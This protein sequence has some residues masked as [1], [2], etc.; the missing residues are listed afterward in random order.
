MRLV[1]AAGWTTG[2]AEADLPLR[3]HRDRVTTESPVVALGV[4]E[5]VAAYSARGILRPLRLDGCDEPREG[6]RG[7]RRLLVGSDVRRRRSAPRARSPGASSPRSSSLS[8]IGQDDAARQSRTLRRASTA[9][10]PSTTSA[11]SR[12]ATVRSPSLARE[13]LM[14]AARTQDCGLGH[15]EG[16]RRL[17]AGAAGRTDRDRRRPRSSARPE[18]EDGRV[19]L[20]RVERPASL[21]AHETG[22]AAEG[23]IR[24]RAVV[25]LAGTPDVGGSMERSGRRTP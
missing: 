18:T 25:T 22:T 19:R 13:A 17:I 6:V 21:A 7:R 11:H 10:S 12:P 2:A 1:V 9:R 24:R 8:R 3:R 15:H 5:A 16:R 23:L 20:H 4:R 14:T